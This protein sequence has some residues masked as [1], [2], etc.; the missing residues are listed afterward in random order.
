MD[1][2]CL[3][4][5]SRVSLG[6]WSDWTTGISKV[7]KFLPQNYHE[8]ESSLKGVNDVRMFKMNRHVLHHKEPIV[9]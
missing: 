7:Q 2:Q 8:K 5:V 3:G 6:R 9:R 4:D 1:C